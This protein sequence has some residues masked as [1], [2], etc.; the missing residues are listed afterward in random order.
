MIDPLLDTVFAIA[1]AGLFASTAAH[2]VREGLRF[3]AQLAEYRLLPEVLVP[4][5]SR[6]LAVLEAALAVA[7]LVPLSRDPAA[8][9]G[10][11]LLAL[12]AAAIAV[13]LLRGRD[14]IDCGCG[15]AA[16]LLSPWL[17]V[18]NGALV[19]AAA[20]VALPQTERAFGV[21]DWVLIALGVTALILL[22]AVVELLLANASALREWSEARD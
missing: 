8:L 1:L 9:A 17:L 5:A 16:T 13:N 4:L 20:V 18:R 14:H 22:W 2:K 21:L 7:L 12:Y 11:A 19:A 15:D 3:E 10:G 6:G